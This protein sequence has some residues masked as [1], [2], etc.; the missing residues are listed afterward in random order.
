MHLKNLYYIFKPVLP[1]KVQL[2]LRRT[3]FKHRLKKYGHVWPISESAG[4]KPSNWQGW[5]ENKQFALVITH[6]VETEVGLNKIKQLAEIDLKYGFKSSFNIV[7]NKYFVPSEIRSWLESNGFEVGIHDYNHDGKLYKSKEMFDIR[8]K[9]INEYLK[10]WNVTGFRSAAMHHN[11]EWL[12]ELDISY[13]CSTF[14][15]DP[16]EPQPDGV[17]TIFPFWY[18]SE[19]TGRGFVEIPYTLPQDLTLFVIKQDKDIGVWK[20]KIKWI[21]EKGGMA[22]VIVH[23]DY[24]NFD[25]DKKNGIGEYHYEKYV[26]LLEFLNS[27]YKNLYWSALPKKLV[28]FVCSVNQ[29]C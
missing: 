3:L 16:F 15:T 11:L 10:E 14:D 18:K 19:K 12:T 22:T 4:K 29:F 27:E 6:D 7:P 25:K 2:A 20:E 9:A 17:D 24:I 21:A 5:P 28:S 23:P 8:A 1:R 13:D 26:S